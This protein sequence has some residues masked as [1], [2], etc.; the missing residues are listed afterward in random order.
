MVRPPSNN[1]SPMSRML[2][3]AVATTLSGVALAASHA[4]EVGANALASDP[5]LPTVIV[6]SQAEHDSYGARRAGSATRTDTAIRDIPQSVTVITEALIK[7]QA[8]QGMADVARYVP[9]IGMANGEGN[10][11]S[12]VFR[13]S[14]SAS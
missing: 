7:D 13:G 9:G 11:D 12:P 5:L 6:N 14:T 3:V 1:L 2:H 8:M 4:A 10:R